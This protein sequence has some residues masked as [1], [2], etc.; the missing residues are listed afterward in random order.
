MLL[1]LRNLI[2]R[3]PSTSTT[4]A[5]TPTR[6]PL[7][8]RRCT[9]CGRNRFEA[10]GTFRADAN[11]WLPDAWLL[12]LRTTCGGTLRIPVLER[13]RVRAAERLDRLH[14]NDLDL[15][16]ELLHGTSPVRVVLDRGAGFAFL[17]ER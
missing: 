17:L 12:A 1:L 9:R 2:E 10:G 13:G 6:L 14:G 7:V 8:V 3:C 4:W 15:V 5:V 11:G 16:A